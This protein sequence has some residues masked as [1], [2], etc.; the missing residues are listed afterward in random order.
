MKLIN[1]CPKESRLTEQNVFNE[2]QNDMKLN[3]S[4]WVRKIDVIY[5]RRMTN[6]T[7][8]HCITADKT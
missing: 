4:L 7:I 2:R 1:K 8:I 3:C 5:Q 6:A